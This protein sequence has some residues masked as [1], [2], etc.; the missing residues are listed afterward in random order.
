MRRVEGQR[1]RDT[2]Q[3]CDHRLGARRMRLG[4]SRWRIWL[5]CCGAHRDS[6][7]KKAVAFPRNSAFI[8]NSRFLFLVLGGVP[9]L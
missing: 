1:G 8:L 5:G 3:T 2:H 9:A 7:A 4:W 6:W